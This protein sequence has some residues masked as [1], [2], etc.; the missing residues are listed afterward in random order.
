MVKRKKAKKK[1]P[2]TW[3]L[4]LKHPSGRRTVKKMKLRAG[5]EKTARTK[6]YK[7]A[8]HFNTEATLQRASR[9]KSVL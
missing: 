9:K 8:Y 4:L 7:T 6:F 2:T 3:Y 1:K 5:T